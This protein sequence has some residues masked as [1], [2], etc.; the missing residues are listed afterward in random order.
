MPELQNP[1]ALCNN[2]YAGFH[3][4]LELLMDS[5]SPAPWLPCQSAL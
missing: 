2:C 5:G 1:A 4:A 3:A